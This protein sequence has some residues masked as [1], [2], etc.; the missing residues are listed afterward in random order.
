MRLDRK[1]GTVKLV[2]YCPQDAGVCE[3]KVTVRADRQDLKSKSFN[4]RGGAKFPLTVKLSS[5]GR[6]KLA[7]AS[8]I[9]GIVFARDEV[10]S[11]TRLIR[12]LK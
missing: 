11:A 10:G 6:K 8:K 2:L 4:Q 1:N 12:T 5:S 7:R 3:G 9:Q